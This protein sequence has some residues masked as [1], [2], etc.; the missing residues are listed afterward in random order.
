MYNAEPMN[1]TKII[2]FSVLA[3]LV[4]SVVVLIATLSDGK[5]DNDETATSTDDEEIEEVELPDN[6]RNLNVEAGDR[7]SSP[8]TLTGEA[9]LWYFEASFPISIVDR[10]GNV[11][12]QAPAQAQGEWM[13]EEFVPFEAT[14]EFD[15]E[16]ETRG[17]IVYEKDNPSGLPEQAESFR[18]PVVLMP[19]DSGR[20]MVVEV[21]F[22]E[23]TSGNGP[24]DCSEVVRVERTIPRTDAPARAALEAL[25]EGPEEDES[26]YTTII[27][28]DV[29][30][31]SL[32]IV[33]GVARVD[34]SDDLNRVAGSCAVEAARAQIE[35]TLKQFSTVEEVVI[36]VEGSVDEALQP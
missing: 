2:F 25:I 29:R 16:E 3:F 32:T 11:L 1:P 13:T 5:N 26:E 12:D 9:R 28:R 14:L 4:I 24:Y 6:L 17:F 31:Q 33:D 7:I 10:D 23:A 8:V 18:L 34:F 19:S 35:E 21:Y 20:E 15:V 27:P 30:I 36:S 22:S